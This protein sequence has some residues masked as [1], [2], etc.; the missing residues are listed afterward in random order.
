[1]NTGVPFVPDN[2]FLADFLQGLSS[3]DNDQSE[4]LHED[5][6]VD[7]LDIIIKECENNKAPGLDGLSY[8]L[9][10]S[11][12]EII[13]EIFVM[14]VQCQL[15]RERIVD[16]NTM[17]ATRLS[18]K[19]LGVPQVD[20][21]RPLTLLN[22]DYRI[23]SKF[24][25]RRMKPVLPFVIKS[26]QLCTVGKKNI[27]FGV[28]NILSSVMFI[29]ERKLGAFL[30]S[31]DFFK[32]YDRVLVDYLVIVMKKMNFSKKFCS[33]IKMLH[34]DA[35][36]RFI[37]G[38][39]TRSI[40]V[41]FSIRQG[42][43][44]S[45][46]LYIVYIEPLL[47]YIEQ[48]FSGLSIASIQPG[49][50]AYCD[51]VNVMSN[52][53]E[54]LMVVDE[55]VRKFESFSGA[56]LSRNKKCQVMGL[57]SWEDRVIWPLD[58]LK[59]VKEIKV[60]GVF[61][62]NSYSDLLRRNWNFRFE[63]FENSILSWSSRVLE[64]IFQRVE[65]VR[66]FALSRIFYLAS[67]LPLPAMTARKIER[68]IGKFLWSASGKIL[69][70]SLDE[71]KNP[72][73]K[74]GCGMVCIKNMSQSL[75]L[76][77]LLRLL[78]SEDS[79]SVSHVGYWIGELLGDFLPGIELGEHAGVNA[80]YFD[81]LA[82]VV[83]DARIGEQVT[84][85]NWKKVTNKSIYLG[86]S[87]EFPV[88]KVEA[89]AGISYKKVWRRLCNPY[90][91]S[92][93]REILFLLVHNKLPVRERLFRINVAVDPYCEYC[94][95]NTGAEICDLEH[96]FC[97]CSRVAETW[98][99]LRIIVLGL[100]DVGIADVS[101]WKIINLCL[102]NNRNNNEV[103]WLLSSYVREVW[104]SLY[105]K[106]DAKLNAAQFFGFLKFKYKNDQLGARMPLN[107]IPGL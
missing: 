42:D 21:L 60:F 53:E 16:S 3:L 98:E 75:L 101:D 94:L 80:V 17:G 96:Y 46:L 82:T 97:S 24:F 36:T 33:W 40:R 8:E 73:E 22:C 65:V 106:G 41:S 18:S 52:K 105:V 104:A 103:I 72:L 79:K 74:G 69:R 93:A 66:I 88:P 44:L 49:L 20:E 85:E 11:T 83:V 43:P 71:L 92:P 2:S 63:K 64:T 29:K 78:K 76:S 13:K 10:K 26:G 5:V 30:L 55:A 25:V 58:Y 91:T 57:G 37:L 89:E 28:N 12:W 70:I 47:I 14:V 38:S 100:L 62:L 51:D 23:L 61:I 27:L 9:Y 45:M 59:S 34:L 50:D 107:Q 77:Q 32:A 84:V 4:K 6:D 68:V 67:I 7:E 87:D 35:R 15:D 95:E 39:L 54:D 90:L 56:I 81:Y 86:Y 99:R 48:K 102:P 19:V 1:M 31:L